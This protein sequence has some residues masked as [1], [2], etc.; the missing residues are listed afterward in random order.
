MSRILKLANFERV[1]RVGGYAQ[2][3]R[4]FQNFGSLNVYGS[5][6]LDDVKFAD[7]RILSIDNW[8]KF[9]QKLARIKR[10]SLKSIKYS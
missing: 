5:L 6:F 9:G 2:P 4:L 3:D 10:Q 1:G 8:E 7:R